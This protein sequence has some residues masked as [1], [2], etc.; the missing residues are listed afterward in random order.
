MDCAAEE[1]DIRHALRPLG[2]TVQELQ[3]RLPH[4]ELRFRAEMPVLARVQQAIHAAGYR[5]TVTPLR[6]DAPS[7]SAR[8]SSR[9]TLPPGTVQ[10]GSQEAQSILSA[11]NKPT[12]FTQPQVPHSYALC[13]LSRG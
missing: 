9:P 1:S 12:P 7:A 2:D 13:R 8:A 5:T 10:S 3:F 4:R 6:D 11:T